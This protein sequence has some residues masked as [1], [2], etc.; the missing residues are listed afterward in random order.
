MRTWF[1]ERIR[2]PLHGF[3]ES[4]KSVVKW[5]L[6]VWKDRDWDYGFIM[7]TLQFKLENTAKYIADHKRYVGYDRD[8]EK[9]R[10]CSRLIDKTRDERYGCEYQ[11]YYK[12]D[13]KFV[14]IEG[15]KSYRYESEVIEDNLAEYFAKYPNDYRRTPKE[16]DDSNIRVALRMGQLREVRATHLL[17]LMM[18]RNIRN[19]WD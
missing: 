5:F 16:P 3:C 9:M 14:P 18:E 15:S 10:T 12:E 6:V 4:L 17:F 1:N 8:V 2:Y 13:G 19:W 7:S 11:D